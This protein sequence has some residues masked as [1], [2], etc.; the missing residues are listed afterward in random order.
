MAVPVVR[1][2][3]FLVIR[4]L[5]VIVAALVLSW[6]V[7]Y[8]GGLALVSDNKDLIFNVHP[9]LMVISLVLLNGEA[10]WLLMQ[11]YWICVLDL[12]LLEMEIYCPSKACYG[13]V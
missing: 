8:R 3:I 10:S 2:P 7:H 9:V 12:G 13:V 11:R 4:A 1:F 6:N 5:G